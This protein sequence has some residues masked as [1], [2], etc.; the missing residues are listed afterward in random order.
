MSSH[1]RAIFNTPF[2]KTFDFYYK[3]AVNTGFSNQL[4]NLTSIFTQFHSF[5]AI[6]CSILDVLQGSEY[7]SGLVF[8]VLTLLV[9]CCEFMYRCYLIKFDRIYFRATLVGCFLKQA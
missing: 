5:I 6:K 3:A 9:Y 2:H 4:K 7:A 8:G 1:F